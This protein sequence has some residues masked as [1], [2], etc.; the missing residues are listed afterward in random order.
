MILQDTQQLYKS[1]YTG[2][3]NG[4]LNSYTKDAV[5]LGSNYMGFLRLIHGVQSISHR[6]PI[7]IIYHQIITLHTQFN[8]QVPTFQEI[9]PC[10]VD[11]L[12]VHLT[13]SA[14]DCSQIQN[15]LGQNFTRKRKMS[16][17]MAYFALYHIQFRKCITNWYC[18]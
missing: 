11:M 16:S 12:Q 10:I 4:I 6:L 13:I 8:P 1:L 5:I 14:S 17:M 15:K 2:R 3:W 18:I 9:I 7:C